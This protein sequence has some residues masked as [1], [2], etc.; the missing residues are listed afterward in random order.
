[1]GRN[2]HKGKFEYIRFEDR[3]TP[4]YEGVEKMKA[5]DFSF[6]DILEHFPCFVGHMTMS[7]FLGLYE[8]Y[9]MTLGVAGHI[10]E[11]GSYKG[12]SLLHF[13]KLIRI[14]ESESL[15]Q[16]HGFDWFEGTGTDEI[17]TFVEAGTYKSSY[18]DLVELIKCQQL[19]Q[20]AFIHRLDVIKDLKPFLDDNLH[21]Q[22]KLV[23]LDAG[24]YN[25]VKSALPL[26]WERLTPGGILILDQYNH[27]LSPGET[28]AVREILPD[29]K[30]RTLPNIWMPTAYI[31]K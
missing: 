8:L 5:L 2:I 11:V 17:K 27:E 6:E 9:K 18:D 29:A 13:A 25:V 7:R 4:Y 30:V 16:V 15:T 28:L 14:F 20:I 24:M 1:M 23:F 19:D 3:R 12:A 31:V 10:A 26:L 22:F 21:M